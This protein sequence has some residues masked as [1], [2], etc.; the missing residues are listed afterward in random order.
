MSSNATIAK[1]VKLQRGD[2]GGTEVF[3]TIGEVTNVSGP[4]ETAPQVDVTSFD[5]TA[6]EFRAGLVDGGEVSFDMNLVGSNAQQQGLRTDLRA[7]TVRNFKL[8]LPDAALEANCTTIAFAAVVTNLSGV[9]A[10]VDGVIKQ[11]CTLKV[12]GLPTWTYATA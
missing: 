1:A 2:G 4:P 9:D 11:S 8:I 6:R 12:S 7:G 3:T 10:A 5:S